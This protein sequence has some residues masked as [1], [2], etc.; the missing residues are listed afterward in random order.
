MKTQ[1]FKFFLGP[2]EKQLASAEELPVSE[3]SNYG[4]QIKNQ[5]YLFEMILAIFAKVV[6]Q[7]LANNKPLPVVNRQVCRQSLQP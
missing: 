7:K 6:P 1:K 5:L 4:D 3:N 2:I